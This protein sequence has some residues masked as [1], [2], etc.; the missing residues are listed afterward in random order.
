M[1]SFQRHV[2]V[3]VNERAADN[4]RGCC[5]ARGGMEV[6]DTLKLELKKHGLSKTIRANNSG[7]LDQCEHGVTVVVYPEQVWYGGVTVDDI[8]EIVEKHLIRGEVVTR[9][10]LPEQPHLDD[11]RTFPAVEVKS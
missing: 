9:L 2:F 6:R 5:K 10:L 7:C 8:P 1:P 11:R 3:C 4:P